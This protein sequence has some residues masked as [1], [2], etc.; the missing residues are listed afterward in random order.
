MILPVSFVGKSI[1]VTGAGRGL[2]KTLVHS[3]VQNGGKVI[4]LSKTKENLDQL[5]K[6]LPEVTTLC[7]DVLNWNETREAVESVG[8]VDLLVNNAGINMKGTVLEA[9]PEDFDRFFVFIFKIK[10]S[11]Y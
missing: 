10:L 3:L 1:L 6:E 4:A 9:T 7:A 2:G 11:R 5:K 8:R